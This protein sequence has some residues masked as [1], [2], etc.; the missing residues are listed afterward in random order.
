ML[1]K[2][3]LLMLTSAS[4][5]FVLAC[6]SQS[7]QS[8]TNAITGPGGGSFKI[9]KRHTIRPQFQGELNRAAGRDMCFS[10]TTGG[11]ALHFCKPDSDVISASEAIFI[12]SIRDVT[13]SGWITTKYVLYKNGAPVGTMQNY[14]S[15]S[16]V[17]HLE[18][19]CNTSA[20]HID[21]DIDLGAM[22]L[23]LD[24]VRTY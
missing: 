7:N 12:D 23:T 8:Q 6:G 14:D 20:Y 16:D 5:L 17:Q 10:N 24:P 1:S 13:P 9:T 2:K 21:C 15:H 4:A 22:T 3:L 18:V 11:Y 19:L